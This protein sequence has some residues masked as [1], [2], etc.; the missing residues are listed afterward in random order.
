MAKKKAKTKKTPKKSGKISFKLNRQ[1]KVVL[2]SFL[3]L[4][5]LA[6][7]VAFISFLFNWQAD[8]SI[9]NEFSNRELEAKNWLSKFG[10][11][12]S[13]FLI[14]RGFGIAAFTLAFLIL[15]SGVYLFFN[16]KSA[17]LRKFWFWGVLVMIWLSIFF[18]F[19][20]DKNAILGGLIG[21]EMNDFLQDYLGF[22]GAVLLML[23]LLIAYVSIRLKITPELVA[24]YFKREKK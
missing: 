11:S 13:D 2:G 24:G 22:F 20:A 10:A 8:Q 16:F 6:L 1:Q 17:N 21:F 23:F 5:G 19:F 7:I 3:M 18:G 12:V 9:L 14:F 15:L 4:F